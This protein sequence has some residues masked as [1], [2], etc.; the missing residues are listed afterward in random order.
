[1][2]LKFPAGQLVVNAFQI[3]KPYF[4]FDANRDF[5]RGGQVRHRGV[6][7]SLN[8][9]FGK[10]LQ[11]LLG[12]VAM[13]P[14]V[15]DRLPGVGERPAGTP[16]LF[17]RMDVNY[18]TDIFGGLTPIATLSYTGKRAVSSRPLATLGDRQLMVPGYATLDLGLR[19]SFKLGSVPMSFRA[20]IWNVFDAASWKVVG[21]NSL[22]MEERR[23]FN[24]TV[25]A[26]F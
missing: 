21:P 14:R 18:R 3:T 15:I 23:R 10:R 5:T 8:G 4:S 11:V 16:S 24:M 9:H 12:A 20:L 22:Y 17:A 25:A 2:R 26:D 13:Q 7:A 19:Q 1:M 6:E